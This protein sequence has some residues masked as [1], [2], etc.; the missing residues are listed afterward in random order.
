M[1]LSRPAR[2]LAA[3]I[4]HHDW[5]DAPFRADRAGHRREHDRPER[6]SP[7]QLNDHETACLRMNVMWVAA[8]VLA[9]ADPNFDVY[10]FAEACGVPT[11]NARGELLRSIEAG[12]RRDPDS[13]FH[14]PGTWSTVSLPA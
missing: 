14:Q 9:H 6:R 7:Q 8:Q 2:E 3:E 12:L 11:R 5:S 10:E 1:A 13:G 4:K